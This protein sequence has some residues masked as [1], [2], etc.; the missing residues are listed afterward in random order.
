MDHSSLGDLYLL[1]HTHEA[2]FAFSRVVN[3]NIRRPDAGFI[4]E[5]ASKDEF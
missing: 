2:T 1:L 5:D 4:R 3:V